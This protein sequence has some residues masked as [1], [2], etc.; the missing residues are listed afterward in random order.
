[1]INA[2]ERGDGIRHDPRLHRLR[3]FIDPGA[4]IQITFERLGTLHC[5]FAEPDGMLPAS[6]WPVRD[7]LEKYSTRN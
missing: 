5:R 4:E 2:D 3:S 6:R 7:A 1:M